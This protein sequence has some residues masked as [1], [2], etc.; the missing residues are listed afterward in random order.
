IR[1]PSTAQSHPTHALQGLPS[2]MRGP[3]PEMYPPKAYANK[4]TQYISKNP[5]GTGPYRF[6]RWVKDE[7]IVL[8]ANEHYWRGA[9][10]IKSVVFRPIPDDAVR[11]AAPQNGEADPAL[12][13]PPNPP[14]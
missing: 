1:P 3:H 7:E 8:E 11:V 13:T 2:G 5:I 6:V 9:A 10:R 14:P 12:N 4:D